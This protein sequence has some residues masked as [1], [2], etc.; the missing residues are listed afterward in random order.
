[1]PPSTSKPSATGNANEAARGAVAAI[2]VALPATI[3]SYDRTTQKAVI[4]IVPCRRRR[5]GAGEVEVYRPPEIPG[6]PVLF[7]GGGDL[8]ITWPLAAGASGLAVFVDR[9]MDEWLSEGGVESEPQDPRRFDI[10]DAVFIPGL[11]SFAEAVPAA[12]TDATATVLRA[13]MIL[14]GSS[15]ASKAVALDPDVQAAMVTLEAALQAAITAAITAAGLASA[16]SG[17][18]AFGAFQSSLTAALAAWPPS[19]GAAKVKAE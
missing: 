14:L 5:G 17:A 18:A 2:N 13:P 16:D 7:P 8:S 15:A 11:R 6:V 3:V 1:M 4:R 12:G 19:M 9:S 10:T